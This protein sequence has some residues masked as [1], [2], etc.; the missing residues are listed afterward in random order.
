MPGHLNAHSRMCWLSLRPG[1]RKVLMMCVY[2]FWA[3]FF[4]PPPPPFCR[5]WVTDG[6]LN[7]RNKKLGLGITTSIC[8]SPFLPLFLSGFTNKGKHVFF[9]SGKQM[10]IPPRPRYDRPPSRLTAPFAYPCARLSHLPGACFGT[11]L[12]ATVA[13]APAPSAF[14][15]DA[16]P[17]AFRLRFCAHVPNDQ[18]A[19][20]CTSFSFP[21]GIGVR[22]GRGQWERTCYGPS[23]GL[24]TRTS[25]GLLINRFPRRHAPWIRRR[26]FAASSSSWGSFS[27]A[28]VR[29]VGNQR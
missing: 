26:I 6:G 29:A 10:P 11:L 2:F 4:R 13:S 5:G 7:C 15:P 24:N 1:S 17:T 18:L 3:V 22:N 20:Q 23:P 12:G 19:Y 14:P 27:S 16:S 25:S 21:L 28:S 8:R 9:W